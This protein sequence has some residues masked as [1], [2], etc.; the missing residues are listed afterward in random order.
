MPLGKPEASV[1]VMVEV[2][3]GET[4][5]NE[6]T[7]DNDC[8]KCSN[9]RGEEVALEDFDGKHQTAPTFKCA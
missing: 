8:S 7:K 6:E 3:R 5:R 2:C 9:C 1:A 4:G